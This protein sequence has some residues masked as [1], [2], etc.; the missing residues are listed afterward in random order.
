MTLPAPAPGLVIRY[1]FLWSHEREAGRTE[2]AKDR[3]CAIVLS[4]RR[5][6]T[7]HLMV[8]VAPVTHSP[9][10]AGQPSVAVPPDVA[11]RL[12]LDDGPA[13]IRVD[14]LNRFAW[15]GFDLRPIPG[16]AGAFAYGFLPQPLFEQVRALILESRRKARTVPRD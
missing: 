11:A 10:S 8:V 5:A 9:P 4:A 15:P 7:G 13:W 16:R 14:E 12:G 3:P 2:A 1:A 6:E